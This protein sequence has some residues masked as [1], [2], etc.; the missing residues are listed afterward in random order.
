M[1]RVALLC[2]YMLTRTC[3]VAQGW[4]QRRASLKPRSRQHR[5][6]GSLPFEVHGA[7]GV[8]AVIIRQLITTSLVVNLTTA[9]LTT[10]DHHPYED[11]LD[12]KNQH[13]DGGQS[14]WHEA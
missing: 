6:A 3:R 2:T 8:I 10:W 11:D 1:M 9:T 7:S 5:R 14:S 13:F 12:C 4:P